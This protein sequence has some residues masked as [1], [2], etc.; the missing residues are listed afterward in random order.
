MSFIDYDLKGFCV[1]CHKNMI[2]EEVIDGRVQQRY[3]PDY[4][5]KEF[6]LDDGSRMRV[7]MCMAD[8]TAVKTKDHKKI[9]DCVIK[10]WDK[11]TDDL[12]K[13]ERFPHWTPEH[14]AKHMEQYS[15]KKIMGEISE[16]ETH[17]R[18]K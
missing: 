13:D 5:E 4:T 6:I 15:K 7:A 9:M 8:A 11:E 12:V 14:K 2:Y 17:G 16:N 1:W 3:A 18:K 10:G